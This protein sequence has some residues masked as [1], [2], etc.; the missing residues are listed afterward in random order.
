MS[1]DKL[2]DAQQ[3]VDFVKN[4]LEP[5]AQ[6]LKVSVEWLWGILVNQVRVEA[7]T[8]LVIIVLL[9]IKA[10]ILLF[11]A[12]KSFKKARFQSGYRSEEIAYVNKK[13]GATVDWNTWYDNKQDYDTVK[14]QN[15]TNFQGQ[16]VYWCG[17]S[18]AALMLTSTIIA[19]TTLPK[20]VTG[21]VNPQY[22]AIE[23]IVQFSKGNIP[24]VTEV[25]K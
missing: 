6:H 24:S 5:L 11:I 12:F 15:K 18:G 22:G 4:N 25:K 3:Y 16:L 7:I 17:L 23:R 14:Y 8:Y 10:S 21:L 19:T 2:E 9:S 13:T 20:I 1:P